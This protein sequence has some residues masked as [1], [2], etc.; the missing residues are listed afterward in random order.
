MGNRVF[1]SGS[2]CPKASL[3]PAGVDNELF[4]DTSACDPAGTIFNETLEDLNEVDRLMLVFAST[5]NLAAIRWLFVLGANADACDTNGTTSLHAACRSGSLAVVQDFIKRDLP[6]DA[7]D[8]A[9]WTAL[10]VALFMGRRTVAVHLMEK[11][12]DLSQRNVR[13]LAPVDLCSDVWLR[14]AINSCAAHRHCY[15]MERPW[16]FSLENEIQEDIQISSRLRFEPFFVPRAPVLKDLSNVQGLQS[17]GVE[18]F[19]SKPGQGLAFLVSTGAVRDFPVELSSFLSE[20]SVC[21]TQVG[22]FLGEDFSLS[23]TLR[24]EYINSVRLMGTGVVSCLAKVF[25]QFH[26]PSDMQKID[27]LI[28]AIAQIWWR[29]H[30]QLKEKG[31]R[32]VH[33]PE[34]R[35]LDS[36]ELASREVEGQRLMANL[37]GYDAMHQ[38]MFSAVMLHWNLYAP[39]PPSQRVTPEKWLEMNA[40]LSESSDEAEVETLR[41]ILSLVYN[42]ISHTFYPQLQIWS[43][44]PLQKSGS[45]LNAPAAALAA[46][47]ASSAPAVPQ[48]DVANGDARQDAEGWVQ[49]VGGGFPS[50]AG[51]SGTI[52]YRHIRSILSETTSTA[53]MLT[54]PNAS[55]QSE[56]GGYDSTGRGGA[57]PMSMRHSAFSSPNPVGGGSSSSSG[58]LASGPPGVSAAQGRGS[59]NVVMQGRHDWVWLSLRNDL[60]FLAPSQNSWAPYAFM[61]LDSVVIHSVDQ[62]N[63]VITLVVSNSKMDAAEAGPGRSPVPGGLRCSTPDETGAESPET[64]GAQVQLIFLLPDGRWQILD[65]PRL[66]VQLPD[67]KQLELWRSRFAAQ[68][69]KGGGDGAKPRTEA[70]KEASSVKMPGVV[71]SDI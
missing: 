48:A 18:I 47:A 14:E 67:A 9:G 64:D 41:H 45:G 15:G 35:D 24:L 52:T 46:P 38:I 70:P 31:G 62:E 32:P 25:K 63:F 68:L 66:R 19:N 21:L 23:Q 11:G 6:L 33:Q 42:M 49:L 39:L 12:A 71:R 56:P 5:S 17:T 20:N 4:D 50:F 37:K 40:C 60:L 51:S 36:G 2:M 44:R 61:H 65:M 1:C 59:R 16:Q 29:Q 22:E 7:T 54:S 53:F 55:R 3:N 58:A 13:G 69:G 27:R 57:P 28:D 34:V 26:I 43:S 30:E 10:H 8:I